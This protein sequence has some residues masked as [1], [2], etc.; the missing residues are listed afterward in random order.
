LPLTIL[1]RA[2]RAGRLAAVVRLDSE[3][4]VQLADDEGRRADVDPLLNRSENSPGSRNGR[5]RTRRDLDAD[6][7]QIEPDTCVDP[8]LAVEDL[9]VRSP[10]W[11]NR[12]WNPHTRG[13][14]KISQVARVRTVQNG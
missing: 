11:R 7:P 1:R 3:A 6:I 2:P 12:N 4:Q 8:H 14:R 9:V 10:R 5:T 13:R